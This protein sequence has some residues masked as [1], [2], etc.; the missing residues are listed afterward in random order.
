[1]PD[2]TSL[3]DEA[4][5]PDDWEGDV[6]TLIVHAV[7]PPDG[8]WDDGEL[9][10]DLEH[11]PSCKQEEYD[12]DGQVIAMAWTCDV[13]HVEQDGGLA[14][15]LRYSGT[16]VTEPGTYKIRGWGAKYWTECGDE[17]DGGVRVV[18]EDRHGR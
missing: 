7:Q 18:P 10:Y 8:P 4:C 13:A 9:D 14:Y 5:G 12:Y 6:H 16:P 15:A 17:Y 2:L 1:M 3:L 11:P